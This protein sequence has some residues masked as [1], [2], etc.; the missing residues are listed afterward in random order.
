M[1]GTEKLTVGSK[2]MGGDKV[3]GKIALVNNDPKPQVTL[4]KTILP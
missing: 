3:Q 4:I 1:P 2:G